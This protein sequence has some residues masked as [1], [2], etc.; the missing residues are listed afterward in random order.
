MIEIA[1]SER[2]ESDA[3]YFNSLMYLGEMVTKLTVLGLLA[4]TTDDRDRNRYRIEHTL[5]RANGIGDWTKALNDILT[6]PVN[7]SMHDSAQPTT[8]SLIRRGGIDSWQATALSNL[9]DCFAPLSL[10]PNPRKTNPKATDWFDAFTKLRNGT[11]AHGAPRVAAL[12]DACP[13][14]RRSIETILSNIPIFT[15]PWAYLRRNLSRKYRVT[16]WGEPEDTLESL[17]RSPDQTFTEGVY[18]ALGGL[19]GIRQVPLISSNPEC[20][21]LW[22]SNGGFSESAYEMLCYIT[23][24]KQKRPS[25]EYLTA[26]EQLP[27]SETEGLGVLGSRGQTFTNLPNL[28]TPYVSRP[29]IEAEL[30]KQLADAQRHF[31]VTLTGPGGIGKTSTAIHVVSQLLESESCPYDVVVWFSARDIDLTERGP[32]RVQPKGVSIDDFATE[33][34][35]LIGPA[36]KYTKTR[37]RAQHFARELTEAENGATLFIFD[38]FETMTSQLEAF[39]WLDDRVRGP[40]KVLITSRENHFTGDYGVSVPGMTE[41]EAEELIVKTAGPLGIAQNIDSQ[42]IIQES[43][44][45]PY[46]IKLLLGELAKGNRGKPDRIIASQEQ[47]LAS[48]FE[49]SYGRLSPAAQ[50]VFLTLCSWRSS[51]PDLVVE[52]V[53]MTSFMRTSEERIDVQEAIREAIRSSFVEEFY[54]EKSDMSELS[55]PLA[56]RL[57]GEK[58]LEVS[59]HRVPIYADRDFLQM[60]GAQSL[61]SIAD[62]KHRI[63]QFFGSIASRVAGDSLNPGDSLKIDEVHPV[64][65]YVARR[66]PYAWL[67][68]SQLYSELGGDYGQQEEESLLQY[69]QGMG[70]SEVPKAVAWRRIADIRAKRDDRRAEL[71][72]LSQVCRQ[73]GTELYMLSAA[74]ND[75][76]NRLRFY[77]LQQDEKQVLLRDVLRPLQEH[78]NEMNGTDWSRLA[79]L[80]V[81]LGEENAALES[82]RKGLER[83]PYNDYCLR[84]M[85]RFGGAQ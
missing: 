64:V 46:I 45:H 9:D 61:T 29:E 1:E 60:L 44:G 62:H 31:V 56:A 16:N 14:L 35:N 20:S 19:S 22:I 24:D 37:E 2:E 58:K 80:Q 41:D 10:E 85:R 34:A 38:N 40:N 4:A 6:G 81:H 69:V 67:L 63:S 76:N 13:H 48:L 51:V 83:E 66:Y 50:R 77:D 72:A 79:W 52:A 84:F 3:A 8:R 65:E 47:A 12:G 42:S 21:A 7:Q 78:T 36:N 43:N 57:F 27:L 71:D 68:L 15:L 54:D 5:V 75:I 59:E 53:M 23:N 33:Y 32:K 11:R 39:R 25:A 55:V 49:R 74:A 17:R 82:A 30:R 73:P 18:V 26:P 70:D 28:S